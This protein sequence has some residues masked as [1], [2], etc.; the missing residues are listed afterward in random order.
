MRRL[1]ILVSGS[2]C[3]W[4]LVAFPARH[5]WG[6][7]ALIFSGVS[8]LLCLVPTGLTLVWANWAME[9]P[10]QQQLLVVLGG[11]GLRMFFV[12]FGGLLIYFFVPYFQN[13]QSFWFWVLVSY[14]V[15]L[16]LEMAVVL[17]ARRDA[18][19]RAMGSHS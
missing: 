1:A 4:L 7:S 12:L 19:G 13:Q 9:Q 2:L 10:P 16:T 15:T 17:T 5:V 18:P 6:D 3:F 11:T 8:I 14:L